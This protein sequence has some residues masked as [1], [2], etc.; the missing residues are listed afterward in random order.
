MIIVE[1]I[2]DLGGQTAAART[3][4]VSQ[5]MVSNWLKGK[6]KISEKHCMKIQ[7]LTGGKFT[8]QQLRPDVDWDAVNIQQAVVS[9]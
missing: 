5:S 2:K 4:S 8:C 1:F 3:L 6:K 7:R 9:E